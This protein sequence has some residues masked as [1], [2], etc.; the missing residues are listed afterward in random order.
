MCEEAAAGIGHLRDDGLHWHA[1]V[2]G[3][4]GVSQSAVQRE[5]GRVQLRHDPVG[6]HQRTV[7]LLQHVQR[8]THAGGGNRR[9]A[10]VTENHPGPGPYWNGSAAGALLAPG[11]PAAT[12]F[13]DHPAGL[14]DHIRRRDGGLHSVPRQ[15]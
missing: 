1:G 9:T 11:P 3:T 8:G 2:H 14:D 7:S 15:L 12:R 10:A 5:G 13:R 4:R 6:D